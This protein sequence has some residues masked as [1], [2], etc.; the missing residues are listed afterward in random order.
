MWLTPP[1][2]RALCCPSQCERFPWPLTRC[3]HT[4]RHAAGVWSERGTETSI[5]LLHPVVSVCV[6][7]HSFHSLMAFGEKS[8][9]I[10]WSQQ[11][12]VKI[13][14]S[15]SCQ[16]RVCRRHSGRD[17]EKKVLIIHLC[18]MFSFFYSVC[19]R[20][21]ECSFLYSLFNSLSLVTSQCLHTT[22]SPTFP[23]PAGV[24]EERWDPS[25]SP[26]PITVCP[27]L[28]ACLSSL[29]TPRLPHH[30]PLF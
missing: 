16:L 17:E 20:V 2:P 23:G 8:F 7:L 3:T 30:P 21:C 24:R 1:A 13:S 22:I 12:A 9:W 18:V 25:V 28:D 5:S 29:T 10:H 11:E 15:P 14:C 19:V 6:G 27:V 26:S 4:H